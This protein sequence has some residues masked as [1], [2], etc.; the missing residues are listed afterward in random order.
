[1]LSSNRTEAVSSRDLMRHVS[2][3]NDASQ[4]LREAAIA[5]LEQAEWLFEIVLDHKSG[6]GRPPG[7]RFEINPRIHA[8]FGE[9]AARC[10]TQRDR[11]MAA[12]SGR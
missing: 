1:M 10:R 4:A 11:W 12:W 6:R 7:A 8:A 9:L 2:A 3:F 5:E